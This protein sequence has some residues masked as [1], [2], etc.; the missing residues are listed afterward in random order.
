MYGAMSQFLPGSFDAPKSILHGVDH[1]IGYSDLLYYS[2]STISTLGMGDITPVS[3][4][5]RSLTILECVIGPL[6]M[7][8]LLARLVS[9]YG[10][11]K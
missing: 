8:I 9:M 1:Q 5:A 7:A 3:S 11:E 10:R 2:F 4:F 6:Y